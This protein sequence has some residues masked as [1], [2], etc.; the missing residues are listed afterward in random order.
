MMNAMMSQ[1]GGLASLAAG[2]GGV[3]TKADLYV[4]LL[5]SDELKDRVV[6]RFKLMERQKVRYRAEAYAFLDGSTD[7]SIGKKDGVISIE[8][9]NEDPKLAAAIANYDVDELGRF[10]T[11]FNMSGASTNRVFLEGRLTKANADLAVAEDK[12]KSFQSKYK[13]VSVTDQ[14]KATLEE[15]AQLRGQ[16]VA[17]EVQLATLQQQFTAQSREVKS[18]QAAIA[19][20][21][22]QIAKREGSSSEGSLLSVGAMP[23][24]GQEY[25]RLMRELKIQETLVELLTKQYEVVKLNESKDVAPFQ[26]LQQ[27]KVPELKSKPRRSLIVIMAALATLLLMFPIAFVRDFFD[28]LDEEEKQRWTALKRLLPLPKFKGNRAA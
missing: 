9:S 20:L 15:V 5:K 24:M 23:Q 14:A 25:V 13:A 26:V 8:V 11:R 18:A 22:S 3:A 6:D 12:L 4:T 2:I 19:K 16:L 10:T 17:Q 28:N 21:R 27:A 7:I 1:M